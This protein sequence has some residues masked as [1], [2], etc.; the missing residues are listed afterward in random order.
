MVAMT[1][2]FGVETTFA[3]VASDATKGAAVPTTRPLVISTL[4][5]WLN[6]VGRKGAWK[7]ST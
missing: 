2:V 7:Q 3:A 5:K 4:S 1:M 6:G